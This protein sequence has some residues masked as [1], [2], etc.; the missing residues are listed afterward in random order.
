LHFYTTTG[1]RKKC[2]RAKILQPHSTRNKTDSSVHIL[3]HLKKADY[4]QKNLSTQADQN[5][6]TK[7]CEMTKSLPL[8]PIPRQPAPKKKAKG[9]S[10]ASPHFPS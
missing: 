2:K 10:G 5:T 9:K 6:M 8:L 1:K 3:R 4:I 7:N